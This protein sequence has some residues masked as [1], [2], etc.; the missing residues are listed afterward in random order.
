MTKVIAC[1]DGTDVSTAVS[2]CASWASLRLEAPL[3]FLHVLDKSEYPIK[4]DLSGNIGFGSQQDLLQELADIDEKRGKLALEQGKRMLE[5]AMQRAI[6]K[7]VSEPGSRQRHGN[8]VETLTGM[9]S[10]I[11]LLILGKHVQNLND[12]I[13]SRVENVV[14]T[15]HRPI[16]LTTKEFNAPQ[17]IM[18]AFDGSDTTRKGVEMVA[19]S[20][21]FRGLTCHLVMV[22]EKTQANQEQLK[23][24]QT[25][26]ENAGFETPAKIISGEVERA[27]CEYRSEHNI[28]MLVMGAYG[29]SVIRRFLIG[30]TTT[31]VIRNAKIPV[32]LLR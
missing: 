10:Q 19:S 27:L 18:I 24:A 29:H 14:R 9:E 31:S 22:G 8:L 21:L 28:H 6:S 7:G 13:G 32:L 11:R 4:S 1:I 16:L 12:H 3:E 20:P 25:L 15:M 30:S 5:A 17:Q 26:L 2:D 23:W